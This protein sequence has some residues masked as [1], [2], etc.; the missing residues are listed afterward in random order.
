MG[1]FIQIL[2][3][4]LIGMSVFGV[5]SVSAV[6]DCII[7]PSGPWPACATGGNT[8]APPAN[9]D[10]IIPDS[11]PWPPCA[12]NGNNSAP[13]QPANSGECIIPAS[14]PWPPCATSNSSIP[15]P[16]QP[17]PPPINA[18][19]GDNTQE[20]IYSLLQTR[21]MFLSILN[22]DIANEALLPDSD[23]IP[24]V[25]SVN[26]GVEL[27]G[28]QIHLTSFSEDGVRHEFLASLGAQNGQPH[29][30]F[31]WIDIN[32]QR[33][34]ADLTETYEAKILTGL[35]RR[36]QAD[37]NYNSVSAISA[38]NGMMTVNYAITPPTLSAELSATEARDLFLLILNEDIQHRFGN[39]QP[40]TEI[41]LQ[42]RKITLVSTFWDGT[43]VQTLTLVARMTAANGEPIIG[44]EQLR[45]ND[46]D[47]APWD[48]T[49]AEELLETN[50]AKRF[51]ATH[52][53]VAILSV[54]A[55]NDTLTIRYR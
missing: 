20:R 31:G 16:T 25:W 28:N 49:S 35:T 38:E 27:K 18:W 34:S 55:N 53:N 36:L 9:N 23:L 22:T 3:C 50:L 13:S 10:C 39:W 33:L 17:T 45:F 24:A 1:R 51:R 52:G 41:T 11:G 32:G 21:D 47:I 2:V 7:P 19:P 37:L 4:L 26:S 44:L 29:F 30:A 8:T 48:R 54:A 6:T 42:Y 15:L 12:T 46:N 40:N 43:Q 5:G 14:G